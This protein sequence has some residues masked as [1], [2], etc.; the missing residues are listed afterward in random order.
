MP[1]FHSVG[2]CK[3]PLNDRPALN[4]IDYRQP[5]AEDDPLTF[6][7]DSFSVESPVTVE[8]MELSRPCS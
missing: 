6:D 3:P 4:G 8:E 7:P 2:R 1:T 5:P